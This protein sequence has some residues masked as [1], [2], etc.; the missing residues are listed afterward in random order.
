METALQKFS[1]ENKQVRVVLMGGDSR[2]ILKDVCNVLGI[3]KYRNAMTRLDEDEREPVK[4]DTLGGVQTMTAINESGLWKLILRSNKPEAK[5]LSKWVTSEVLPVIRRTGYYVMP[6]KIKDSPADSTGIIALV[7][8]LDRKDKEIE[9]LKAQI[10]TYYPKVLFANSV[11]A[12]DM[13]ITVGEMANIL[14]QH[15]IKIGAKDLYKWLRENGYLLNIPSR[16]NEPS[17]LALEH[18]LL[19]FRK[20][21]INQ[22]DGHI[23]VSKI[24]RVTSRGQYYFFD[25]IRNSLCKLM[26]SAQLPLPGFEPAI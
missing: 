9:A 21:T 10:S 26:M 25:K 7:A 18:G 8:N 1:F 13:S 22:P 4:V 12:S 11:A 14:W 15:G 3:E 6:Q 2:W 5:R 19:E 17:Q 23:S 16:W 24:T 20:Y